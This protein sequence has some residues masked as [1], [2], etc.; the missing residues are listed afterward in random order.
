MTRL[1]FAMILASGFFL[2]CTDEGP[3]DTARDA[4]DGGSS[5]SR[6]DTTM[7][8]FNDFPCFAFEGGSGESCSE[9]RTSIRSFYT[10][11][12]PN[13]DGALCLSDSTACEGDALCATTEEGP[14][15]VPQADLCG[16]PEG[17]T[18]D[19]SEVCVIGTQYTDNGWSPSTIGACDAYE[20]QSHGRCVVDL[21][22]CTTDIDPV[23]GCDDQTYDNS[24]LL[25]RAGV[26]IKS[27][28]PCPG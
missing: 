8:C 20:A 27:Q 24:C 28:G 5:D 11:V 26:P 15:C 13:C 3:S 12:E 7:M 22:D 9:D 14:R 16:G 18:C 21:A 25:R 4:V 10:L 6:E 1:F 17:L 19:E 2:S 23:C